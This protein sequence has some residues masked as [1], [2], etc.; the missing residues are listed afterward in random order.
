MIALYLLILAGGHFQRMYPLASSYPKS[1]IQVQGR[2]V[3][4]HVI[5]GLL[6]TGVHHLV[7]VIGQGEIYSPVLH[8]LQSGKFG[9]N[10]KID[11]VT[12]TKDGVVGAILSAENEFID[13][14]Q[15]F[16]AHAD[17][18]ATNSFYTHLSKTVYRTGADG[19]IA[20]TLKSSIE[21]FG[22][23]LLDPTG[24]VKEV[25][26]HPGHEMDVG[27]YIGAGAYIFPNSIFSVLKKETNFDRAINVL[28]ESGYKLAGS[29]FS[30]ENKWQ[31]IGTPYDLII[32][33][34]ILFSDYSGTV[35]HSSANI[36]PNA[37]IIGRVKV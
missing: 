24:N 6:S 16:L 12:Q 2:P 18:M 7:V 25:I 27:N 9:D 14:N 15:V 26:E 37:Q 31:D 17:I 30:D 8:Y 34:E 19:G 22:V 33:N 29:I 11:I 4:G 3:L 28:I 10:I 23:C 36:S 20:M 1:M 13:E 5:K 21:D 35:I 32:A